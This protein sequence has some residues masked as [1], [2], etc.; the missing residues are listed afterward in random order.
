MLLRKAF[1][2]ILIHRF[3]FKKLYW[4]YFPT[5]NLRPHWQLDSSMSETGGWS[6][7]EKNRNP[8]WS[9]IDLREP[10]RDWHRPTDISEEQCGEYPSRLGKWDLTADGIIAQIVALADIDSFPPLH[11]LAKSKIKNSKLYFSLSH[12]AFCLSY[13]IIDWTL[14]Y[15]MGQYSPDFR[16]K[17]LPSKA[18]KYF[19]F[20]RSWTS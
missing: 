16:L 10:R 15:L 18:L 13:L 8:S 19:V 17:Y 7:H 9:F 3:A 20:P 5:A 11:S 6:F 14:P 4:C 12:Y 2:C 1:K